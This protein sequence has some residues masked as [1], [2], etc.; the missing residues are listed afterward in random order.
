MKIFRWACYGYLLSA[1]ILF[2]Y[3]GERYSYY[4]T[5]LVGW[6]P[7]HSEYAEVDLRY[8]DEQAFACKA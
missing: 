3:M 4:I 5:G 6:K 2:I 7:T 1:F 8:Y